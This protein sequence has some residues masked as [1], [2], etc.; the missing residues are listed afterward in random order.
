M[1]N[2]GD[3]GIPQHGLRQGE[4][5][6]FASQVIFMC[7]LGY[8]LEGQQVMRCEADALWDTSLPSCQSESE[9]PVIF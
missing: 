3:P 5:F 2:C 7:D 6:T 4:V 8:H 1:A 9:Y